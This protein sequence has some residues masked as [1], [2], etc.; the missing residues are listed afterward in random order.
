[1]NKTLLLLLTLPLAAHAAKPAVIVS[2]DDVDAPL[3][4]GKGIPPTTVSATAELVN[5][6]APPMSETPANFPITW[7]MK[8]KAPG[9]K[10]RPVGAPPSG[11]GISASA[12]WT[13]VGN[14]GQQRLKVGDK[15]PV[16]YTAEFSWP[17][18]KSATGQVD[19]KILIVSPE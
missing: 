17:K 1:M 9:F 3:N 15:I 8:C 7:E 16:T 11:S 13:A 12:T 5:P 4:P 14:P 18:N 6:P 19:K 10:F 2:A